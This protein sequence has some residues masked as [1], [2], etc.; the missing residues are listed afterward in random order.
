M[1]VFEKRRYQGIKS[2]T[3]KK[4]LGKIGAK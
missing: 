3:N 2:L 1:L 4:Y